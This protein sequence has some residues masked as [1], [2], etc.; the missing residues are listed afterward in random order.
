Y[1]E[2]LYNHKFLNTIQLVTREE[3][4]D[5][6]LTY[7]CIDHIN[8]MSKKEFSSAVIKE[9]IADHYFTYAKIQNQIEE[10]KI[11]EI[12]LIDDEKLNNLIADF[13][14]NELIRQE[15]NVEI[16][17]N[18]FKNKYHELYETCK[19]KLKIKKKYENNTWI[20]KEIRIDIKLKNALWK[21]VKKHPD[22]IQ[23]KKIY[24]DFRNKLTNKIT[25]AKRNYYKNKFE[26][27]NGD[28]KKTWKTIDS[29]IKK[30]KINNEE[31][32][33]KNFKTRD[34]NDL[35]NN[36][37][38]SF[39]HEIIKLRKIKQGQQ[40][41]N[42]TNSDQNYDKN[43]EQFDIKPI[44]RNDLGKIVKDININ[45]GAGNDKIRPKDIKNNIIW[46]ENI[47]YT[48]I[49]KIIEEKSIP[50]DLKISN[51]TPVYKKGKK[52]Q[53]ENYRPIAEQSII[54]KI[55]EKHILKQMTKYIETNKIL[56]TNQHGFREKRNTNTL[57]TEFTEEINDAL[58]EN[59]CCLT[60]SL[61]LKKAYETIDH[62]KLIDVIQRIGTTQETVKFFEEYFKERKQQVKIGK[63]LSEE[64]T[65]DF[66][67]IQGGILSPTL[68]N[69]FVNDIQ[70]INIQSTIYQYADDTLLYCIHDNIDTAYDIIQEDLNKIIKWLD[71]KDI[72]LNKEK[73]VSILF[74]NKNT[75]KYKNTTR[76]LCIHDI[77]CIEKT[78][79]NCNCKKIDNEKKMRYLGVQ[80]NQNFKWNEHTTYVIKKLQVI[81]HKM[82]YIKSIVPLKTKVLIYKT[83][84]EAILRYGIETYGYTTKTNTNMIRTI[85]KK[86]IKATIYPNTSKEKRK[87]IMKKYKILNFINLHKYI[88]TTQYYYEE[89]YRNIKNTPYENRRHNYII[90]KIKNNYGKTMKKYQ[91]PS[92]LNE[93]PENLREIQNYNIMK[94]KILEFYIK[95]NEL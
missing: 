83:M 73:T 60:L 33:K 93:L 92:L 91:I 26:D 78:Y 54:M 76:K 18:K 40:V 67:L 68:F 34:T 52:D 72:Y 12:E 13:N 48:I 32:L 55:L 47:L 58:N 82:N 50:A 79:I 3:I 8:I 37:N 75:K 10:N 44:T 51:I 5:G 87:E 61:D 24:K 53:F 6:K 86:I 49:N 89:E 30:G 56:H 70:N 19:K 14:W 63:K 16:I 27:A 39:K 29:V 20:T 31:K 1:L 9:K 69:I 42:N 85:H 7:S 66:G 41:R 46:F 94:R 17:Y 80:F 28:M 36:F 35:A 77:E 43:R 22:N 74:K 71:E 81:L 45:K 21:N 23:L 15:D 38:K 4:T 57:L 90:P 2:I 95:T 11:I 64:L 84:C 65:L 25:Q 59:K 62:K 88:L